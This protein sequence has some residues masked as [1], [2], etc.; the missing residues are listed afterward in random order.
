[1]G[2]PGR[3]RAEDGDIAVRRADE[4]DVPA[5]LALAQA[6]LRWRPEEPNEAYFRWKHFDNP[7]G[8]SPMWVATTG[9]RLVGFRTFL[10]WRFHVDGELRHAVRAVDTATHPDFQG[11][12]IFRLLT[13]GA[14]DELRDEGVDFVFNTPNDQSRPGYLKMGWQVVGR[15]PIAMRVTGPVAA[16]KV[17]RSRVPAEK[18]SAPCDVGIPAEEAL[19]DDHDVE[20]LLAAVAARDGRVGGVATDRTPAHLRWRYR[21]GPLR[22]RAV[23]ARGGPAAGVAVF[24]LRRRG[25]ALEAAVC[26]V[27][28]VGDPRP[29]IAEI[30]RSTGADYLIV[31]GDAVAR[32]RFVRVPNQGPIL[33]WRG[34]QPDARCPDLADLG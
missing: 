20:R 10:R 31:A 34:V 33:T 12:G 17:L 3:R 32:A 23:V 19:A 11:R 5:V 13:T 22:Y 16:A 8:P 25:A 14:L 1:M 18:W 29:L 2:E 26:E 30:A 24:R 27:L 6:S 21:F 7:A 28:A 9:D 15:V 4:R